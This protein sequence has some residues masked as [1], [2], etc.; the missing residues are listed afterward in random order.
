MPNGALSMIQNPL[1]DSENRYQVFRG[2]RMAGDSV[3]WYC[4]TRASPRRT[5]TSKPRNE[6]GNSYRECPF[7]PARRGSSPGPTLIRKIKDRKI[8]HCSSVAD[9]QSIKSAG[10]AGN[11]NLDG[12][13]KFKSSER[14]IASLSADSSS[15]LSVLP[16]VRTATGICL[17]L[18]AIAF[19]DA[20]VLKSLKPC[21]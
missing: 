6:V 20:D 17:E 14:Y 13:T 9:R 3:F 4:W 8:T 5:T 16:I 21:G 1:G 15:I 12:V 2:E 19:K 11:C 18:S 7:S 10:S